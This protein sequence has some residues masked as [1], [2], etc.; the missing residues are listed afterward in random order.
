MFQDLFAARL[1]G[2]FAVYAGFAIIISAAL[3]LLMK[4]MSRAKSDNGQRV[5]ASVDFVKS[6]DM[7]SPCKINESVFLQ[8]LEILLEDT[9][10]PLKL[11]SDIVGHVEHCTHVK[12][13]MAYFIISF[14][15]CMD[16]ANAKKLFQNKQI[17]LSAIPRISYIFTDKNEPVKMITGIRTMYFARK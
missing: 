15:N 2:N 6:D 13:R 8:N 3:Y 11:G 12:D 14:R 17:T 16:G 4:E 1:P 7:N 9:P 5:A 10:F